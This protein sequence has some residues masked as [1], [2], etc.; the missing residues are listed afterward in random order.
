MPSP[1][2]PE[3]TLPAE[4]EAP[5]MMAE[6][7]WTNATPMPLPMPMVPVGSVPMKFPWTN[8]P[9]ALLARTPEP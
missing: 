5:P 3:M 6:G 1:K 8:A 9:V 2:S 4:A 7:D